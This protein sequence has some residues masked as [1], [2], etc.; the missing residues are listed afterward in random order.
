M[1]LTARADAFDGRA[2]DGRD[3]QQVRAPPP[4]SLPSC[5]AAAVSPTYSETDAKGRVGPEVG[6]TSAVSRCI[7]AGMHGPTGIFWAN[8]TPCSLQRSLA[9][10]HENQFCSRFPAW[11]VVTEFTVFYAL[12]SIGTHLVCSVVRVAVLVAGGHCVILTMCQCLSKRAS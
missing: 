8:L 5:A 1:T 4:H 2:A 3:L 9:F 6:P 11:A 10:P 7:S 12:M